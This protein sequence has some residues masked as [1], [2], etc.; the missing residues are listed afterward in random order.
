MA[1]VDDFLAAMLPRLR[2]ADLAL[3]NGDAGPRIALWSHEDPVTVFGAVRNANGWE[4][5]R[6]TFEWLATRFS[7]CEEF[8]LDVIAAGASGDLAYLLTHEH[9][10]AAVAGAAAQAYDLRVTWIFRR[11]DGAWKPVHRHADPLADEAGTLA[12]L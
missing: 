9:T 4:E 3:H 1:E 5:V 12:Q 6:H 10:T 8:D 7:R 11:E 2:E